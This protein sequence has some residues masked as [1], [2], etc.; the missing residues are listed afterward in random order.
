MCLSLL[1]SNACRHVASA[2]HDE[3]ASDYVLLSIVDY[4]SD[5]H[6]EIVYASNGTLL[7]RTADI[8]KRLKFESRTDPIQ[9]SIKFCKAIVA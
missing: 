2:G 5:D 1:A 7:Q 9:R 8:C 4:I 3:A 6:T